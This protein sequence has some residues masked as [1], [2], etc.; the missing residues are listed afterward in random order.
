MSGGMAANLVKAGNGFRA[1][2]LS[3]AAL[4][5]NHPRL[6]LDAAGSAETAVP[7]AS[8]AAERHQALA[9]G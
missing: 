7:A 8:V 6:A 3:A 5:L 9:D 1:I 2:Y 4:K